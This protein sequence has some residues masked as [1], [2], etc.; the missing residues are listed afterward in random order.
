[1]T[2]AD[3]RFFVLLV[4]VM[5][6]MITAAP[7]LSSDVLPKVHKNIEWSLWKAENGKIYKHLGE[8]MERYAIWLS[9]KKYIEQH[10]SFADNFGFS[11][12]MNE[13][14]DMVSVSVCD[15]MSMSVLSEWVH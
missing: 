10:N 12:A 2:V 15:C 7:T 8:E 13:F 11:L 14:G 4:I 9:N 1:M 3:S 6:T 5:V